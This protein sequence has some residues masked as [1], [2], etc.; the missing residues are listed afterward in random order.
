MPQRYSFVIL[1]LIISCI[2]VFSQS[3][4]KIT[5]NTIDK[6]KLYKLIKERKGKILFLNV[7]ATWCI[8]CREEFPAIVKLADDYNNVEFVGISADFPDEVESK[9]IPILRSVKVNYKN[10]VSG[11]SG[12][13]ELINTLDEKWNG[14]L[15]ATFIYDLKGNKQTVLAGK[16]SY[17]EFKIEIQKILK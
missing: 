7:W 9:I 8:P 2:T 1:F 10:F 17:D 15:P 14:A 3:N 4:E 16:H 6:A 12:D 13:E 11:F 5:V